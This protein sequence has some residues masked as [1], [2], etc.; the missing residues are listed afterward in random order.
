MPATHTC[1]CGHGLAIYAVV[2]NNERCA[3]E[4]ARISGTKNSAHAQLP[5]A[6]EAPTVKVEQKKDA[7]LQNPRD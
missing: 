6:H 5:S 3:R 7:G 2:C 4:M 1:W